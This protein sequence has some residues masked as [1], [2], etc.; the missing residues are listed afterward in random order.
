MIELDL[1]ARLRA[2]GTGGGSPDW[3]DVQRRE[4]RP[5]KRLIAFAVAAVAIVTVGTALALAPRLLDLLH[6]TRS[7]E[8]VPRPAAVAYVAGRLLHRPGHPTLRLA[9]GVFG[10]LV[11]QSAALAVSSPDRRFVVYHTWRHETPSLRIVD[12]RHGTDR[13]LARGAQTLAWGGRGLAFVRG[14]PPRYDHRAYVGDVV[15]RRTPASPPVVWSDRVAEYGALAWA[16][17]TLLVAVA[18]CN[19]PPCKGAREPGVY[20]FDGP[21]R[22]RQLTVSGVSAVSPDG[23]LV[24]GPVLPVRGQDSPSPLVHLDDV[25]TGRALATLDLVA[26]TRGRVPS[27][28]LRGGLGEADWRGDT[29]VGVSSFASVST[30]VALRFTHG[31]L[32]LE[33]VLRLDRAPRAGAPHGAFFVSPVFSGPGT[34][35]VVAHVEGE[36]RNGYFSAMI[37]C[38][39]VARR[40]VRG[41]PIR[42]RRWIAIVRNPSRPLG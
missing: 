2:L 23:R 31:R 19:F 28:W 42:P 10:P 24:V 34:R 13:V 37:T 21:G 33:Q 11:G 9:A 12:L 1:D 26:A 25:R 32:R 36:L 6:V 3:L 39:R 20:A 22:I 15:V 5:R 35:V 40:C 38:D 27:S 17:R 18:A 30:L 29:I 7:N 41:A 16:G 8:E 4:R 14:R